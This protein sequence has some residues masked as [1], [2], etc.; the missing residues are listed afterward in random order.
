MQNEALIILNEFE[1]RAK[2]ITVIKSKKNKAVWQ[3]RTNEGFFYL[4]KVPTEESFLCF[5]LA[6]WNHLL[7]Q[8]I[9]MPVP[10]STPDGREYVIKNGGKYILMTAV[11]G[12]TP[13]FLTTKDRCEVI[14]FLASFH[15]A[16][17][18]FHPPLQC[19]VHSQMGTL[20][21]IY[22]K[23]HKELLALQKRTKKS[24]SPLSQ[25]LLAHAPH[26][27]HS[28]ERASL[29]L[30]E[31]NYDKVCKSSEYRVLA[32]R[33]FVPH[34]IKRSANGE[35]YVI[36]TDLLTF[37]LPCQDIRKLITNLLKNQNTLNR[38]MIITMLKSYHKVSKLNM[39]LLKILQAEL[40]FPY[41]FCSL[42]SDYIHKA[43]D[44]REDRYI[45][46]LNAILQYE[47]KKKYLLRDFA[48]IIQHF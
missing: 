35:L 5:I 20:P 18:K 41:L 15:L 8:G 3:I 30:T 48:E 19:R 4:K 22:N 12:R 31:S 39:P 34:N 10:V 25:K 2:N 37:N 16:S 13:K 26:F 9:G 36:D 33:D 23:K 27:I 14:R 44:A 45:Q 43:T 42:T 6:A 46:R 7:G 38:Q 24:R 11:T 47:K 29:I 21:D 40:E 28:I 32:H 17:K 1:K